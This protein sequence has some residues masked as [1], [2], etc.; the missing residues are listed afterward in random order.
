[1]SNV[2]SPF[3]MEKRNQRYMVCVSGFAAEDK[4]MRFSDMSHLIESA[5]ERVCINLTRYGFSKT[6]FPLRT[7]PI[8]NPNDCI[9]C[10][11]WVS[12]PQYFVQVYLKSECPILPT[13]PEWAIHFTISRETWPDQFIKRMQEYNKLNKIEIEKN[14]EKLKEVPP[15]D[16]VDNNLFGSFK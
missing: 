12:N 3:K 7:A 6:C 5:C 10:V 11:G 8:P 1:M 16:L 14:R 4:W 15:M 9:I 2:I 13:S